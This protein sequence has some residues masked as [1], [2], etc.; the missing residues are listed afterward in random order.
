MLFLKLLSNKKYYDAQLLFWLLINEYNFNI[1]IFKSYIKLQK[2]SNRN[3]FI[4][5]ILSKYTSNINK[6]LQYLQITDKNISKFFDIEF[7]LKQLKILKILIIELITSENKKDVVK[8]LLDSIDVLIETC[9]ETINIVKN[10]QYNNYMR[11]QRN[12]HNI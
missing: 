3:S 8:R 6:E 11:N 2:L 10:E 7:L 1:N 4:R 9:K 5:E 12:P